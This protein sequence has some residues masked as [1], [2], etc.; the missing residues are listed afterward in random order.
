V[1][2]DAEWR[3]VAVQ[4]VIDEARLMTHSREEFLGS[5][6]ALK[7]SKTSK[8]SSAGRTASVSAKLAG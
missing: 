3:A 7:E 6:D 2:I 5:P 1:F 4:L 8:M